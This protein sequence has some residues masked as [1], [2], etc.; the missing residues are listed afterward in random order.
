ML[1]L[2]SKVWVWVVKMT[3]GIGLQVAIS[4]LSRLVSPIVK[5]LELIMKVWLH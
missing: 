2:V 5:G 4:R 3:M 1:W